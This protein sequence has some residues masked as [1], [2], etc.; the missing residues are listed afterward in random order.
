MVQSPANPGERFKP[1]VLIAICGDEQ[2]IRWLSTRL[3]HG[4]VRFVA[5]QDGWTVSWDQA[6]EYNDVSQIHGEARHRLLP[7]LKSLCRDRFARAVELSFGEV[8]RRLPNGRVEPMTLVC[9][10]SADFSVRF[11]IERDEPATSWPHEARFVQLALGDAKVVDAI[12]TR[13]AA[14]GSEWGGLY[15]LREIIAKDLGDRGEVKDGVA[16]IIAWGWSTNDWMSL[17]YETAQPHRHGSS[18]KHPGNPIS[19]EDARI[20]IDA[21]YRRWIDWKLKQR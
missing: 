16:R 17:F 6:Q 7:A 9:P 20:G 1:E 14:D 4:G 21:I 3:T 12:T 2:C 11:D 18:D 13:E 8:A 5:L 15:R 10:V 19:I